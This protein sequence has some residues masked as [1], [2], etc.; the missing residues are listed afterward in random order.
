MQQLQISVAELVQILLLTVTAPRS[1]TSNH[2]EPHGS[3]TGATAVQV[4][5]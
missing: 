4:Q 5:P 2:R 3:I 1:F